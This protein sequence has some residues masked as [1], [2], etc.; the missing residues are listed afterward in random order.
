MIILQW[1]LKR[2]VDLSVNTT[3]SNVTYDVTNHNTGL[4]LDAGAGTNI[5]RTI[6][7]LARF[8]GDILEL[9]SPDGGVSFPDNPEGGGSGFFCDN[10]N[11]SS[12]NTVK[13]W[14]NL[15]ALK[16]KPETIAVTLDFNQIAIDDGCVGEDDFFIEF[17][18]DF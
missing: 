9:G 4:T 5:G 16:S 3:E 15:G 12:A 11:A 14:D 8:N 13:F 6:D 10:L 2:D 18:G 1:L 17:K 7:L